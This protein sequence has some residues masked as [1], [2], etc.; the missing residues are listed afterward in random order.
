M[1]GGMVCLAAEHV[2]VVELLAWERSG[3]SL[4]SRIE[5]GWTARSRTQAKTLIG[6]LR[7]KAECSAVQSAVTLAQDLKTQLDALNNDLQG[8][9]W[10]RGTAGLPQSPVPLAGSFGSHARARK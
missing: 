9:A 2:N 3:M 8:G 1:Q 7:H 10:R 4:A 6:L 5:R